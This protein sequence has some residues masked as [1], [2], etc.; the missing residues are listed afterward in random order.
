[1]KKLIIVI[2][3]AIASFSCIKEDQDPEFLPFNG[4][5][6]ITAFLNGAKWESPIKF[7]LTDSLVCN[8]N[9]ITIPQSFYLRG[10]DDTEYI[11]KHLSVGYIQPTFD[12]QSA[13]FLIRNYLASTNGNTPAPQ[14]FTSVSFDALSSRYEL[15]TSKVGD[16]LQ[17]T[18]YDSK[19]KEIYGEFQL[20]FILTYRG[21]SEPNAPDRIEFTQGKFVAK[22]PEEW[23]QW[24]KKCD[25]K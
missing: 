23:F 4:N 3:L 9:R 21:T 16:F 18:H 20:S 24:D 12:K 25:P 10:L 6:N 5:G 7:T 13:S 15:D 17:L 14:Y 19:K 8:S 1:M 11:W 22:A 2:I